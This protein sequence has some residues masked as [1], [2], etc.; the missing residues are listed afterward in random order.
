MSRV[1]I[2]NKKSRHSWQEWACVRVEEL[3]E[4]ELL[5]S[6]GLLDQLIHRLLGEPFEVL[7]LSFDS[8]PVT[9]ILEVSVGSDQR[10]N[11]LHP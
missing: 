10:V 9:L 6:T 4:G 1:Q 5:V 11:E 3:L 2:G 8:V 7:L